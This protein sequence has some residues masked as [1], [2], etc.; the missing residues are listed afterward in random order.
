MNNIGNIISVI[1]KNGG[2][3]SLE[4]IL[5]AYVQKW[6]ILPLNENKQK[7]KTTLLANEGKLVF[8]DEKTNN[9]T[10]QSSEKPKPPKNNNESNSTSSSAGS[11]IESVLESTKT[12]LI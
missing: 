6:H 11:N 5:D 3:A 7:I 4:E 8:Y 10:T 9:W 2:I 1:N 12:N